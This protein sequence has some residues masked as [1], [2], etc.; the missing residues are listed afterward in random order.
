MSFWPI[1]ADRKSSAQGNSLQ[2]IVGRLS[3]HVL[4]FDKLG[5]RFVY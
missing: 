5:R 3:A 1:F 2:R 4:V